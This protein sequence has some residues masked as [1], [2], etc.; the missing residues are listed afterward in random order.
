MMTAYCEIHPLRTCQCQNLP[1]PSLFV[2]G[3]MVT[4]TKGYPYYGTVQAVFQNRAGEWRFV[5]ERYEEHAGRVHHGDML[6]I[7]NAN[8]LEYAGLDLE[9]L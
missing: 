5:V 1:D 3:Q 8:Q 7:F 9:D 4:K 6:H 2:V